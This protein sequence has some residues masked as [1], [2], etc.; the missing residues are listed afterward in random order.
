[1]K[2]LLILGL[3]LV[4]ALAL[5]AVACDKGETT[6]TA[7]VETTEAVAT[8]EAV[9]ENAQEPVVIKYAC[10]GQETETVGQEVKYF[11]DAV[12]AAVPAVTFDIYYGGTLASGQEDLPLLTSGGVD[13]ISLGHPPYGA[14][15][16]LVQFPMFAPGGEDNP[17]AGIDYFNG[18]TFDDPAT[19]ALIQAE[20]EANNFK[21][22]AWMTTGYS[23]FE[24]KEPFTK[25]SDLVG[26]KFGVGAP[27]AP[28]EA[29][30]LT[31][32]QVFPPDG[33]ESLRTGVIDSTNMGFAPMVYAL[34]WYEV[35]PY[36]L[37]DNTIGAGQAIIINL[38]TWNSLTPET[39]AA[40]QA[41]ADATS[42]YSIQL[43]A[44]Q[45]AAAITLVEDAGGAVNFMSAE[46]FAA[47]YPL[48]FKSSADAAYTAAK[49]KGIETDM[50][51]VLT[52]AAE[53]A[54]VTWT[55]PAE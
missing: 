5:V 47:Y 45:T 20:A 31:V 34:K 12:T 9:V 19:S 54:N 35:A 21:Y 18:L 4:F 32:V 42:E 25:I 22:L 55:P 41:A 46:D 50:A 40:F 30:G 52:K 28:Y 26:G 17:T 29:L 27:P 48:I 36:F 13:M 24:A 15:I 8:T 23:A 38:D 53:L 44:E 51:T 7:A 10:T 6:T 16:P 1:M 33:Y 37:I 39:Q 3:V 11:T 2:K 49:E 43:D 14:V